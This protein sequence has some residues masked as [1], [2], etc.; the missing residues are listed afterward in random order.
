MEVDLTS[1]PY[2]WVP[3]LR[4]GHTPVPLAGGG[5]SQIL[6]CAQEG[7]SYGETEG[8]TSYDTLL[9]S[10]EHLLAHPSITGRYLHS[11]PH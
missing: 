7:L 2:P 11:P 1:G 8:H 3:Y 6:G 10:V 9:S 4:L 5:A